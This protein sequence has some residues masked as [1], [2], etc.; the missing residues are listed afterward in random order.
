[1]KNGV[2]SCHCERSIGRSWRTSFWTPRSPRTVNQMFNSSFLLWH[3]MSFKR[4]H[5]RSS[6]HI[7]SPWNVAMASKANIES[8]TQRLLRAEEEGCD[9]MAELG[10]TRYKAI[11]PTKKTFDSN[12][13]IKMTTTKQKQYPFKCCWFI[14][15]W[16]S[17]SHLFSQPFSG[18]TMVWIWWRNDLN[19][20]QR[21][22]GLVFP[23]L[24]MRH[25]HPV[26]FQNDFAGVSNCKW[27]CA[28]PKNESRE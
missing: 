23:Q 5:K 13:R 17:Q 8:E 11:L 4:R 16:F 28:R 15:A 14:T 27:K 19:V 7:S 20:N 25:Q 12:D 21:V 26:T 22:P 2:G 1:M 10:T 9:F 6:I 3:D 18:E 24:W